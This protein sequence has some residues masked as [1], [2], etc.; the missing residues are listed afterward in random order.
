MELL[1]GIL[2]GFILGWYFQARILLRNMLANPDNMI[3]LLEQYKNTPDD[4]SDGKEVVECVVVKEQ[5][6]FYLYSKL[7][8]QFLI[9]SLTLE[10]ALDDLQKRFPSKSFRGLIPADKAEEWGLSKQE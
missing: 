2:I 8:N 1:I 4:T 3:K 5:D 7:D 9:Q 6:Q 10:S